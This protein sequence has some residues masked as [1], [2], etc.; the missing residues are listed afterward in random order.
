MLQRTETGEFYLVDLGSRNGTFVNGRRV[1]IPVVLHHGDQISFGLTRLE[2]H[3]PSKNQSYLPISDSNERDTFTSTQYE[4]RLMSVMVID[5]R[6]FTGL[7]Q[8]LDEQRLSAL[9]SQWFRVSGGILHDSGCLVD[10]YIGDAVMAV[11]FHEADQ[12]TPEEVR[13]VLKAVSQINSMTTELSEQN[14][15]HLPFP[16][17]IGTGVNTGYAMLGKTKE[18]DRP[19]YTAIGDTVNT[20]FRLESATKEIRLDVVLGETTY[21]S[22]SKLESAQRWFQPHELYLKGYDEPKLTYGATYDD[23]NHFLSS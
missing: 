14:K 21:S 18:G 3:C 1:S 17:R 12:A 15:A 16:L 8:Q 22:L 9:M 4:R 6:N 7:T 13:Q 2:F 20:A 10:K 19:Q 11:W 5:I 23:L